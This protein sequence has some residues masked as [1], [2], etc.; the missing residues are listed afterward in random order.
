MKRKTKRLSQ[1]VLAIV[2]FVLVLPLRCIGGYLIIPTQ[3]P[4]PQAMS[5]ERRNIKDGLNLEDH[6][7]P[8]KEKLAEEGS[9]KKAGTGLVEILAIPSDTA[10]TSLLGG[11]TF[12]PSELPSRNEEQVISEKTKSLAVFYAVKGDGSP[13]EVVFSSRLSIPGRSD[14]VRQAS[15]QV[16][17]D[18]KIR[19]A[20]LFFSELIGKN[21]P[22]GEY[23]MS[24]KVEDVKTGDYDQ[25]SASFSKVEKA[26]SKNA[27]FAPSSQ[28]KPVQ[29]KKFDTK[30]VGVMP[31]KQ[32]ENRF[33][34]KDKK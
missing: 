17:A 28:S 19:L 22:A 1:L 7:L 33:R 8:S 27:S 34:G 29:R 14:E 18:G 16:P 26:R 32:D 5:G 4:T 10:I 30:G 23:R 11:K 15:V 21:S 25:D 9:A 12:N 13:S 20:P 6:R 31:Q 3:S 24:W 2:I